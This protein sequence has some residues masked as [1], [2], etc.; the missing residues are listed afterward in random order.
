MIFSILKI[1]LILI[2]INKDNAELLKV[3]KLLKLTRNYVMEFNYPQIQNISFLILRICTLFRLELTGLKEK[4]D[5]II[6]GCK[7]ELISSNCFE[8]LALMINIQIYN[9]EVFTFL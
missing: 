2:Q 5:F 7:N 6:N 1:F 8:L 9:T 3:E 4:S